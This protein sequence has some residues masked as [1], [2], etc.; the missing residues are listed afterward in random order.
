MKL[1]LTEP[2]FLKDSISIISD[3]VTEARFRFTPDA[4]E[5]VAM[6]PANV[7]M[8]IFKLL[9]SAFAEYN[10]KED[11][12][13]AI[14]MNDFKQ[15]L[16]RAKSNDAVTLETEDN[17]FK[18]TFKSNTI[19]TFYLPI[20]D[21]DESEQKI[22]DLSF[23]ATITTTAAIINEAIEDADIVSESVTFDIDNQVLTIS[24]TGDLSKATIR[25]DADN[26]TKII[27]DEKVKSK[28]SIEYLKKMIQGSKISEKVLL[29]V[30]QDYPLKLE[31]KV[32]NK[33]QLAFIL[34][35]R[36]DND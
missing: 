9:S 35:P 28:F 30:S 15:V 17:K 18:I 3:L 11:I 12:H 23:K 19:R 1:T 29:Q 25:I 27:S 8:V 36:V 6:D 7:A 31:Y 4:I 24:A 5:L 2:K 22:P 21:V 14:N 20:I 13:L 26:D 16:R 34:A 33:V 10:V 32:L